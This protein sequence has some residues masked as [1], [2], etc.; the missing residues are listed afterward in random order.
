M[1]NTV[2]ELLGEFE[3]QVPLPKEL[4]GEGKHFMA[5]I[6]G[7]GFQEIGLRTGDIIVFTKQETASPGQIIFVKYDGKYGEQYGLRRYYPENGHIRLSLDNSGP[8]EIVD[9][10]EIIGVASY[11]ICNLTNRYPLGESI[12]LFEGFVS[13]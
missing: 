9:S 8:D 2:S 7:D 12:P 4:F 11:S 6:D 1:Q 10:C 13:A 5:P 3:N